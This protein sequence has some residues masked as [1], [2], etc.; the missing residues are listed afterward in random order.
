LDVPVALPNFLGNV[1]PIGDSVTLHSVSA[2][3]TDESDWADVL[4]GDGEAFGRIF[5]RHKSRVYRHSFRLVDIAADADDLVSVVFLEAW[6]HRHSMRFVDG[7]MLPWLLVTATN[8]SRN[9]ERKSHR[10]REVL[11]ELPSG[12]HQDD[13]LFDLDAGEGKEALRRLS[14]NDQRVI[15][16][17]VLEGY[18]ERDAAR[19][20]GIPA[21]TV[22]SRLSRAKTRLAHTV[23]TTRT[24]DL[25]T[26]AAHEI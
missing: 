17:C 23:T 8:T 22:K 2:K 4:V 19:V 13:D 7:S 25:S 24:H 15:T 21:G 18:S 5:D 10:Y 1:E 14:I 11:A 20:L 6:R 3:S 26:E 12:T 16:L 9:L